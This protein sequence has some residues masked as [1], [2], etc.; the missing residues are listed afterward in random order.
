MQISYDIDADALYFGI[1]EAPVDQTHGLDSG[2]LVDFDR[3]GTVVGIE[4]IRPARKW[5]LQ[6]IKERFR[7]SAPDRQMLDVFVRST[8]STTSTNSSASST[9]HH[10]SGSGSRATCSPTR[11]GVP[12]AF[13]EDVK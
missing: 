2:T 3:A 10:S 7:L 13:A 12:K 9:R 6:E 4:V 5:P 11:E 8:W 1:A